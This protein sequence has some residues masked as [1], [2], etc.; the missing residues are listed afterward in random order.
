MQANIFLYIAKLSPPQNETI[1]SADPISVSRWSGRAS[2]LARF[3]PIIRD[4][5]RSALS[6]AIDLY[7]ICTAVLSTTKSLDPTVGY[8]KP[9][10]G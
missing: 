2:D 3:R 9:T 6:A 7:K 8:S 1:F 10:V 4:Q 5:I